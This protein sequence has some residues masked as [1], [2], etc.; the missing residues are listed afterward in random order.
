MTKMIVL[1]VILI[2]AS[3]KHIDA[4][5]EIHFKTEKMNENELFSMIVNPE[6]F[7]WTSSISEHFR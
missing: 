4:T 5:P 6:H 7:N 2:V 3:T 1:C